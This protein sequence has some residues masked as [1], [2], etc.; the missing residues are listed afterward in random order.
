MSPTSSPAPF[1]DKTPKECSEILQALV[2]DTGSEI[3]VENFAI[4]DERSKEDDTVW[5]VQASKRSGEIK[6][7]RGALKQTDMSLE[8]LWV[9][10]MNIEEFEV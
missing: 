6:I 1:Q 10:N 4:L 2:K 9:G 8:N 5:L 7:V 3:N